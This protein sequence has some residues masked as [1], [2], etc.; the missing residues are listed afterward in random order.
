MCHSNLY[1]GVHLNTHMDAT[2]TPQ[3]IHTKTLLYNLLK[4]SSYFS[5]ITN[6]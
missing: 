6:K 3:Y 5:V 1:M 4:I 2:H